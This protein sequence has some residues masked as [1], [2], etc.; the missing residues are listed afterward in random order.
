MSTN[1][2]DPKNSNGKHAS[3][4]ESHSTEVPV[5]LTDNVIR[6]EGTDCTFYYRRN[7]DGQLVERAVFDDGSVGEEYPATPEIIPHPDQDGVVVLDETAWPAA[8]EESADA[9]KRP[10]DPR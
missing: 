1:A 6:V 10:G 8:E 9:G 3:T 5:D 2:D 7:P 4:D